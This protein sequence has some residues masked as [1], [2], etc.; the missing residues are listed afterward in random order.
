M[1]LK[2]IVSADLS[3]GSDEV[4]H[5]LNK[6]VKESGVPVLNNNWS[7]KGKM[8]VKVNLPHDIEWKKS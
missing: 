2:Q 8:T 3:Y 4:K 5:T 6:S 7:D 1:L